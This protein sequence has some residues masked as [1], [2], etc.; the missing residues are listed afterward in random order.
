MT[1]VGEHPYIFKLEKCKTI[2]L[3]FVG[4]TIFLPGI[5]PLLTKISFFI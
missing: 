2:A 4:D 5:E 3:E 1:P